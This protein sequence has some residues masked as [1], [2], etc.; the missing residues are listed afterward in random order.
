MTSMA[1]HWPGTLLVVAALGSFS[2][3]VLAQ[4]AAPPV[5]EWK[6]EAGF[7]PFSGLP[8]PT[9]A[10]ATWMPRPEAEGLESFG[11]WYVR[12]SAEGQSP[13]AALLDSPRNPWDPAI[14]RYRAE[15]ARPALVAILAKA[16]RAGSSCRWTLTGTQ[17][18]PPLNVTSS[19]ASWQRFEVPLSGAQIS[20]TGDTADDS[21]VVGIEHQVVIGLGDSYGSGEGNP[22]VPTQWKSGS[23]PAGSYRWLSDPGSQGSLIEEGARWWDT[24]C[25]RSFWSHQAYIAMRLAAVN[26]HRL[27]T[28]LHYSCS[29]AEVFDGVMVRQ[30]EPPGMESCQGIDCFLRSSQIGALVRDLCDGAVVSSSPAIERIRAG[31]E[32]DATLFF[33]KS[34]RRIGLDLVECTGR[35]RVPDLV[36]MSIGGNDIGFGALAGWAVTPPRA[37]THVGRLLGGYALLRGTKV[38]C[39]EMAKQSGCREPYDSQLIRQLPRRFKPLATALMEL[40]RVAPG[41]VVVTTYPDPL[42]DRHGDVCG[43]PSGFRPESPWA[44]AHSQ[45][46]VG[47]LR[48]LTRIGEKWDFNL[49][50]S[51]ARILTVHTLRNLRA[52]IESS[53]H[54][55]GFRVASDAAAAFVGHCWTERDDGDAPTALPSASPSAWMCDGQPKGS[56]VCWKPFAP[57]RRFIRTINDALLTQ[58]SARRDDMTGAVHPTAQGHAAVADVLQHEVD[59]VLGSSR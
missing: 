20:V 32:A 54:Q 29:A 4:T 39:P 25:H 2:G 46:P 19:C 31:V 36:L 57:R 47:W 3:P 23:A 34:Y 26:P 38:T 12:V 15:Y 1:T 49:L 6:V 59:Q 11:R 50:A 58:S 40:V 8:D 51:E 33:M 55:V 37:R 7:G 16:P 30:H 24:A 10:A 21:T 17:G 14:G 48:N 44:G 43:D 13:Y 35:L 42:R 52:T 28:F 18:R 5:L 56:P 53:A 27:V 22:D 9:A 41:R 45:L